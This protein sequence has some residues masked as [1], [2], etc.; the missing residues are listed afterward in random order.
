MVAANGRN[1]C[2]ADAGVATRGLY[3]RHPWSQDPPA[4]GVIDER[5][6]ETVF[7]AASWVTHLELGDN[8]AR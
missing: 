4:L 7:H 8:A 5:N 2:K 1:E 3:D 6:A